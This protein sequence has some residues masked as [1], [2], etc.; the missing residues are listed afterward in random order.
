M[1]WCTSVYMHVFHC[2][3]WMAINVTMFTFNAKS[4]CY[5]ICYVIF[6]CISTLCLQVTTSICRRQC[7][8]GVECRGLQI[9]EFWVWIKLGQDSLMISTFLNTV[10]ICAYYGMEA[11][12][13]CTTMS[14]NY[15]DLE[16]LGSNPVTWHDPLTTL[17]FLHNAWILVRNMQEVVNE[18]A[19]YKKELVSQLLWNNQEYKTK[20]THKN[21]V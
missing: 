5:A 20:K 11:V 4:L 8:P 13:K 17:T 3:Y 9:W 14:V 15:S 16:V 18:Y 12:I 7:G 2:K 21:S 19:E 6:I 10:H 1:N